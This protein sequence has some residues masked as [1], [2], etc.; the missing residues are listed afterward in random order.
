MTIPLPLALWPH[1]HL[2]PPSTL[3]WSFSIFVPV[4]GD[5]VAFP[6]SR[7]SFPRQPVEFSSPSSQAHVVSSACARWGH[8]TNRIFTPYILINTAPVAQC[9]M[10]GRGSRNSE[11]L[12]SW[13]PALPS[14]AFLSGVSTYGW[15]VAGTGSLDSSKCRSSSFTLALI[16]LSASSS[17]SSSSIRA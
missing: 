2:K 13:K 6:P 5:A 4:Q 17:S 8:A 1:P 11:G 15:I 9:L 12:F 16:A 3:C 10:H 14:G 7:H